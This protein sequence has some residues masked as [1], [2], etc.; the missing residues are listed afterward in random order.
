MA[1]KYIAQ[2]LALYYPNGIQFYA[3]QKPS[4]L[5]ETIRLNSEKPPYTH[6]F[7]KNF[8]QIR[9][10]LYKYSQRIKKFGIPRC[11]QIMLFCGL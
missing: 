11:N 3:C 6:V 5:L 2:I 1:Q 4:S 8:P 10:I 9:F 7:V